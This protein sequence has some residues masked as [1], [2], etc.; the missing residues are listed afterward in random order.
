MV[1]FLVTAGSGLDSV[2]VPRTANLISVGRPGRLRLALVIAARVRPVPL[3][4]LV[5]EG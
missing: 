1:I 3:A 2:I 4:R 5:R